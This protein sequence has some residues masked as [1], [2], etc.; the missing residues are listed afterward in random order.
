[1][2]PARRYVPGVGVDDRI[3]MI[4]AG[5][6]AHFY[7]PD[8][9]GHVI[10]VTSSAGAIEDRY[11]YTPYGFEVPQA[12][13]GQPFRYTGRYYDAETGLLHYRARYYDPEMGRFLQT[14]PIRYDD[15]M[16]LYDPVNGRDPYGLQNCEVVPEGTKDCVGDDSAD[17]ETE[18]EAEYK[19]PVDKIVVTARRTDRRSISSHLRDVTSE[20]IGFRVDVDGLHEVPFTESQDCGV[21][22]QNTMSS[23]QFSGSLGGGHTHPAG[24]EAA[25]GPHDGNM[26]AVTGGSAYIITTRGRMAIESVG[27][28]F[29]ARLLSGS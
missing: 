1:M 17:P 18:E 15:Q 8:R 28:S 13:S 6:T 19:E 27:G 12:V 5:G 22:R 21:V 4:E 10:A 2:H 9:Q 3:A 25:P 26:A 23:S 7:H 24:Y 29:R 14:D 11:I 16:N 20:E